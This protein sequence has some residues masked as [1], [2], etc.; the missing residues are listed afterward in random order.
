MRSSPQNLWLRSATLI[1]ATVPLYE[2]TPFCTSEKPFWL[3]TIF[4]IFAFLFFDSVWMVWHFPCFKDVFLFFKDPDELSPQCELDIKSGDFIFGDKGWYILIN[5]RYCRGQFWASFKVL[6]PHHV[7][8]PGTTPFLDLKTKPKNPIS[9][10]IDFV[11]NSKETC[12]QTK[13]DKK[14]NESVV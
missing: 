2:H 8:A 12:V 13:L 4:E 5:V 14:H 10:F 3:L 11:S 1:S 7:A 9:S 6:W